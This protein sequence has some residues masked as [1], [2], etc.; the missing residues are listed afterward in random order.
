MKSSSRG[1]AAGGRM[2][3]GDGASAPL[4]PEPFSVKL[5]RDLTATLGEERVWEGLVEIV[6]LTAPGP[7]AKGGRR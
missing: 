7:D 3:N 5:A 1:F 6:R 2:L 4:P